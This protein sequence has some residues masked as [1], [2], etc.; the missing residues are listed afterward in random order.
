MSDQFESMTVKLRI[1]K[2]RTSDKIE[3]RRTLERLVAS[4]WRVIS[5]TQKSRI[6]RRTVDIFVLQ[7]PSRS[8]RR[9][10]YDER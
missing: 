2:G 3:A 9:N 8:G 7:R 4:G 10:P 6:F 1:S 5:E